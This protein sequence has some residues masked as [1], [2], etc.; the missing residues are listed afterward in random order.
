MILVIIGLLAGTLGS[1]VGLGGGII[2][3]PSLLFVNSLGLLSINLKLQN[4][5]GISLFVII[6]VSLSS[7]I[8]YYKQK[9]VDINSGL[10]FFIACGPTAIIG[11]LLSQH[12]YIKYFYIL[13][14]LLM[15]FITYLLSK[16][17]KLKPRK[18]KWDVTKVHVDNY[19]NRQEYG[20]NRVVGFVVTGFAG[21]LA[22]L[23]GIGGGTILVP[24]MVLLF[25]FPIQVATAT[26]MFIILLST[27]SG[28]I[29]HIVLGHIIFKYVL[30]IGIGAYSGG[31]L[32][33]YIASKVSG[34]ALVFVLQLV[35]IFVATQMIYTGLS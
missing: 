14:G 17:K 12:I 18:I 35:I 28:S 10:F 3:V 19:G 21:L 1:I 4:V 7:T 32:G 15:L 6:F 25:N 11:S 31:K 16:Q 26:S 29:S 13:F 20:Y 30:I 33:S 34:K 8:Y 22:G 23:F 27:L 24:M 5:V 9:K 2:I